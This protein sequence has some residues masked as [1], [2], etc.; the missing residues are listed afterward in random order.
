[1]TIS[2]FFG[3]P[4][5]EEAALYTVLIINDIIVFFRNLRKANR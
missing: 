1:M 5:P 3:L 4:E 2:E